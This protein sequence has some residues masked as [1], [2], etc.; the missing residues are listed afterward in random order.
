MINRV[1]NGQWR[2]LVLL[3]IGVVGLTAC[4]S[5]NHNAAQPLRT[6]V[7]MSGDLSDL[8][9]SAMTYTWH[10]TLQKIIVDKRL[11]RQQVLQ[12]MQG[13]IRQTLQTKGYIWVEDPQMADFQVGFGVAMGT[14]MSDAQILAAAGLVA[15][16]STQG[17][18]TQKYDKGSVLIA[19]FKPTQVPGSVDEPIWRVL[20]Q[21]FGNIK[22]MDELTDHFDS[23][24]A[25]MLLNLPAVNVAH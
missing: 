22:K 9:P 12:H 16:L 8:P 20:A 14:E 5:V 13:V 11:D 15:G 21:G 10:P 2:Q 6:T 23:L 24:I 1:L 3:I 18:D 19:V 25:E 7:V 17:V 4:M